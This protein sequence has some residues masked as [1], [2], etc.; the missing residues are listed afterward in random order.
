MPWAWAVGRSGG[1][2]VVIA[3]K[4]NAV[5][6]ETTR[7]VSGGDASP[8]AIR[9]ACDASLR[10]LETD[11]IDLYQFHDN[12]YPAVKAGGAR[13]GRTAGARTLPTVPGF[14]PKDRNVHPYSCSS[15]C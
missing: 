2:Q 4:F 11:Y 12:E 10:R 3:T 14:L 13:S 5:F 6:D 8:P 15:T 7:R 9:A 1:R